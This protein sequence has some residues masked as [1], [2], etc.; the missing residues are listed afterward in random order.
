[1]YL[2]LD[3]GGTNLRI[4]SSLDGE[5]LNQIKILQT[6]KFFESAIEL[7]VDTSSYLIEYDKIQ[8]IAIGLPGVLDPEK[9]TLI[10]SPNLPNWINFAIKTRLEEKYKKNVYLENDAALAGLGE[11]TSGASKG[12]NL[13][14]Y[15]TIGTGVGGA[16]IVNGKIDQNSLGFE[17]GH[18]IIDIDGLYCQSC[19]T[20]G[21]LES[22]IGGKS[23]E[24]RFKRKPEDIN[25]PEFWQ[26][27]AKFLSIGINNCLVH[28]SPDL[29]VLGGSVAN[30]I[31][32][33]FLNEHIKEIVK[34]FPNLPPIVRSELGDKSGLYGALE[35]LK[36]KLS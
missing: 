3:I 27:M 2:L 31:P 34:I 6:P 1:M 9:T 23:I 35:Y 10:Q 5:S 14:A 25:D 12:E 24:E 19:Q 16:R 11:A 17:I 28:W 21:H 7:I 22:Y 36:Q 20:V 13:V 33:D 29:V 26:D 30:K 4:A 15:I 18:Q 32:I 8:A